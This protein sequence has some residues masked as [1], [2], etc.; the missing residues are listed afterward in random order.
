MW[1]H[2]GKALGG[3][4]GGAVVGLCVSWLVNRALI[5]ISVNG[6]FSVLFGLA[7]LFMGFLI[8]YRVSA[9]SWHARPGA[10]ASAGPGR[11]EAPPKSL[12]TYLVMAFAC[13]VMLAGVS[14]LLLEKD[15]FHFISPATKVPLY[16]LLGIALWF[17]L[18]FSIM[19]LFNFVGQQVVTRLSNGQRA[20]KPL[21]STPVQISVVLVAAV[22][23]GVFFGIVFGT[24]D[25][26]DGGNAG[27]D[28][29]FTLPVGATVCGV[30]GAVNQAYLGPAATQQYAPRGR[31]AY[32]DGI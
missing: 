5:E 2:G 14:C 19:D 28:A 25:V 10:A 20:W 21:I 18:T 22:L 7:L 30:V 11:E 16:T 6:F 3:A 13:L 17:A 23:L 32:D 26:E 8:L 31:A 9:L 12:S 15:W 1:Q 29:R 4:A 27:A 24:L